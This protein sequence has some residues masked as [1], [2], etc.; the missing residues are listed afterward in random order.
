[1]SC[2][3]S[4]TD[5]LR[6]IDNDLGR[7]HHARPFFDFR[8]DES[9]ARGEPFA[10]GLQPDGFQFRCDLGGAYDLHRGLIEPLEHG[11][12]RRDGGHEGVPD[13][14]GISRYTRLGNGRYVRHERGA[15]AARLREHAQPAVVEV[16]LGRDHAREKERHAARD[17]VGQSGRGSLVRDVR[18]IDFRQELQILGREMRGAAA[19]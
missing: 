15:L 11:P 3:A 10:D 8:F 1:V 4:L 12:R 2:P 13:V 16:R 7:R 5:S 6:T 19:S 9:I 14:H 18:E 17:E